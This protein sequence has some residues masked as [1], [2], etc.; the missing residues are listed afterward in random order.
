MAKLTGHDSIITSI[1]FDA[2][3]DRVAT[4]DE[5][6][7]LR[8]WSIE[9]GVVQSRSNTSAQSINDMTFDTKG[10]LV[11][12]ASNDGSIRKWDVREG[13]ERTDLRI[14]VNRPVLRIL[15]SP[16]GKRLSVVWTMDRCGSGPW[17]LA[18]NLNRWMAT[19]SR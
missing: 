16:D 2:P 13:T 1:A 6:G 19:G 18:M 14:P 4:A 10:Q 3:R 8:I 11:I 15:L 5:D 17:R 12:T 7:E 9:S